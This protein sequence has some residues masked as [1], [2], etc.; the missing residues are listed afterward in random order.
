MVR[1]IGLD[2][3]EVGGSNPPGPTKKEKSLAIAGLFGFWGF[4]LG[5]TDNS[6]SIKYD[7]PSILVAR[8]Q[9]RRREGVRAGAASAL[10]TVRLV[11][12]KSKI[13]LEVGF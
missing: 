4:G 6:G 8:A 13:R 11:L 9:Q 1:P 10:E 5:D 7:F 2:M 12:P 3:V